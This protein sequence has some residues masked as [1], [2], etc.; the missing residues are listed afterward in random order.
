MNPT[1]SSSFGQ[2]PS[3]SAGSR[4]PAAPVVPP[5][6]TQKR[7]WEAVPPSASDFLGPSREDL[8]RPLDRQVLTLDLT[9]GRV[10]D[11]DAVP[12][13]AQAFFDKPPHFTHGDLEEALDEIRIGLKKRRL[14]RGIPAARRTWYAAKKAIETLRALGEDKWAKRLE[15][16]STWF[17]TV[18]CPNGHGAA[19]VAAKTKRCGL[20]CCPTCTRLQARRLARAVAFEMAKV[21][22]REGHR[23]RLL[24]VAV[25]PGPTHQESWEQ[26]ADIRT[27]VLGF[28]KN[29][30]GGSF[31]AAVAAVEFGEQGHPHLHI[32]YLGPWVVRDAL[33]QRLTVWT[34]GEVVQLPREEWVPEGRLTK[35]GKQRFRKWKA[36]GGSFVV[37]VRN[38]KGGLAGGVR[39]VLK[40]Q[41][42][43]FRGA[44]DVRD[45]AEK[46]KVV[47]AARL[48]VAVAVAGKGRHRV[49][50]YGSLK[51]VVS[52][53]LGKKRG[54][55]DEAVVVAASG[56]EADAKESRRVPAAG[57]CSV[58]K[59]SLVVAQKVSRELLVWGNRNIGEA[60][61][62]RSP[63]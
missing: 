13:D 9:G 43:I 18:A 54:K 49:Q 8:L 35:R 25:R 1:H 14:P 12:A 24:T 50:G 32:L 33:A 62:S 6:L 10:I 3:S 41:T 56:E 27:K 52:R 36:V 61:Q 29:I 11:G 38:V 31:P 5:P 63:H 20:A 39:E 16:C 7:R 28:L 26:I 60:W 2:F 57:C 30:N 59:A 21:Q 22:P 48:A 44:R 19:V 47:G 4:V 46:L 45:P 17:W 15:T 58:C 37:D 40:Y 53:A 42:D 23:W 34:G 55:T 51:G